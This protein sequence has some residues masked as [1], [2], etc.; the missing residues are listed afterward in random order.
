MQK[1]I[2]Q[3]L[4]AFAGVAALLGTVGCVGGSSGSG[5]GG[6]SGGSGGPSGGSGPGGG[7]GGTTD[8]GSPGG[9]APAPLSN[10]EQNLAARTID[11]GQALRTAALKLV[12]DLPTLDEQAGVK[13]AATYAAQIDKYLADPRIGRQLLSYFQDMFKLGGAAV[14]GTHPSFDTAPAFAAS[15]AVSDTAM[16]NLFTATAGT[17][18]TFDGTAN[19]FTAAD[20]A[21]ANGQATVGVL[22]DPGVQSQFFSNMAFRRVRWVQETFIC[23]KF[24]A[25]YSSTP[26]AMGAGQ[27]VS[28]WPFTSITGGT[29]KTVA[30]INFQD[31]SSVICANCH[32]TMNHIAPLFSKFDAQGVYQTTIQVKVPVPMTP[33]AKLTDWLPSTETTSYR[34]QKPVADLTALGAALAA[35]P[36]TTDCQVAR[37]WNWAMSK[38]DI[39]NDA[40]VVPQTTI[41]DVKT[42]YTGSN[43]KLK[44]A[45]KAIFTADDFVK[46]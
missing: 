6:P 39:V 27:Y 32:S 45:L 14:M 19:T 8:P 38:T 30:P 28:P 11:Y 7:P 17:C 29:D 31:T 20:C 33:T 40:A 37:A 9:T 3:R 34:F 2:L 12:G 44:T 13:D 16:T 46:F 36:A 42:A 1:N 5:P 18:P 41:A 43:F 35:D 26:V 23:T 22:T 24:P 25:E 4:V 21:P 10:A 15:L